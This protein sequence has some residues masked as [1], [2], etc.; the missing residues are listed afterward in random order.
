MFKCTTCTSYLKRWEFKL[1]TLA[2]RFENCIDCHVHP[3]MAAL[4]NTS[5]RMLKKKSTTS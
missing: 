5:Y 4:N 2:F 1:Q 3:S